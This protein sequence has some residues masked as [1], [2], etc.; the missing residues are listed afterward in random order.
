MAFF[1]LGVTQ[2]LMGVLTFLVS[3]FPVSQ[4]PFSVS[5]VS[6]AILVLGLYITLS[7]ELFHLA[8]NGC[9]RR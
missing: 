2:A 5:L 8:L 6:V 4:L 3:V 9:R 7:T 1:S